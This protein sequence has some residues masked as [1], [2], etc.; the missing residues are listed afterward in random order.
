M[1]KGVQEKPLVTCGSLSNSIIICI[2][3]KGGIEMTVSQQ[4]VLIVDDEESI[5]YTFSRFLTD[6]GYEAV[7]ARSYDEALARINETDFD[8]VFA[9]IILGGKSG[10]DILREVK[11]RGLSCPVIMITGDPSA[12]NAHIAF[13]LGAFGHISKPVNQEKLLHLTRTALGKKH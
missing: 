8:I 7:T 3:G 2:I 4:K 6:E 10:I 9:D 12:E 5:R 11:K 13:Q 1:I